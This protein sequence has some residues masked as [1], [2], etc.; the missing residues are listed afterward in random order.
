VN[1]LLR[2]LHV[3]LK[4]RKLIFFNVLVLTL[5]AAIVSLVLPH[6][7][8]ATAQLLPPPEED[9]FGLSSV[10]G[11]GLSSGG[12]RRLIGG[13][14]LGGQS[15]SDLMVGI[16]SSRTVMGKVV[17]RCSIIECS[18]VKRGSLE[19]ALKALGAMTDLSVA[20]DGIVGIAVEAKTPQLAADIANC[21]VEEL[22]DFLRHSNVSSGRNMRVFIEGRLDEV[23]NALAVV[24][25]SLE[26]FQQRHRVISIDDE[27]KAAIDAYADLRSQLHLEQAELAMMESVSGLGNP[28]VARMKRQIR[29]M[30]G[31]LARLEAGG[32]GDGFGVGF[33]VSFESL[34]S[35]AAEYLRR[36]RDFKL[37]DG[38][39]EMLYQ[40]LEYAKIMEARDMPTLTVL[41]H[42]VPPERRS[43][44]HRTV[45]IIVVLLF[46][47]FAGIAF[48]FVLE[49]FGHIRDTRPEEYQS[50]QEV[51]SQFAAMAGRTGGLLSRKK[52]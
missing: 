9:M 18:R 42:A 21:Y 16:L 2:Y 39:Y 32:V 25:E 28:Q 41:D 5:I 52:K 1:R 40:Q 10:L 44:P 34:P 38:A 13:G 35:V 3:I 7:Y 6:R 17:E 46:G 8:T 50:W 4:W 19:E 20:D 23:E 31:Q 12:L 15:P 24:Q 45:I 47:L 33:G 26:V 30:R 36:Y 51:R 37:Q 49:Y 14:K 29:A 48:A 27:T 22:D 43:S 11:G